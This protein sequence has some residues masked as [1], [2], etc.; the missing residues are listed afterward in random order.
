MTVGTNLLIDLKAALQ[1]GLVVEAERTRERPM[2]PGRR[3][4]LLR[5]SGSTDTAKRTRER[6]GTREPVMTLHAGGSLHTCTP[7]GGGAEAPAGTPCRK[8]GSEIEFGSGLVRSNSPNSGR[9]TK[10]NAK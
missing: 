4:G 8:T 10:K 9:I 5:E 2:Q 7:G 6:Q 3:I 1:L